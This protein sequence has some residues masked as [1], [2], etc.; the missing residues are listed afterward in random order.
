MQMR[1]TPYT[2]PLPAST[3]EPRPYDAIAAGHVQVTCYV[4][5]EIDRWIDVT[6]RF[7]NAGHVAPAV[8]ELCTL[9]PVGL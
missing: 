8:V 7:R 6:D 2:K 5:G 4:D 3:Y 9:G 1:L